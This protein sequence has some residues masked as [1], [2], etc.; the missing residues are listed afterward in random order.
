MLPGMDSSLTA[1]LSAAIPLP[2]VPSWALSRGTTITDVDAAF[3]AGVALN[4]L[5]NLVRAAPVWAGAWRCRLGLKCAV[6]AVR[7][8]GRNE[9]EKS[10][11][12]AALLTAQGGDPGPAG[13]IYFAYRKLAARSA[14]INSKTLRDLA[15]LLGLRW[16]DA[17]ADASGLVDD[18]V[19]P[20]RAAPFAVADLV[21]RVCAL[22]P[23]AEVLAWWLA[24]WLLAKKL[25]WDF[26]VP[27]LMAERYGAAFR[28]IGGR[29]RVRPG[30]P[31][32]ERAV[33][34][35][36]VEAT[37]DALRLAA[38]I[39]RRAEKLLSVAP[40]VRTKGADAV[41]RQ[42]FND[43]AV[44]GS[45]PGSKLSRWASRRLFERLESLGAVR[46]LSGRPTFRIYGL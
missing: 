26:C 34:L 21:T 5:D 36:L 46:E 15:D 38:E 6:S 31:G 41:F 19:Q 3:A 45:A 8:V 16:D 14:T 39:G 27:L 9:E 7:L 37:S 12:D 35:A 42:L 11:R 1:S 40:K 43:D 44:S 4:S 25:R 23:D 17:L 20:G 32:F 2:V 10:L 13:S 30:E 24:D 22:R 29:G 28:T 18:L 33:C